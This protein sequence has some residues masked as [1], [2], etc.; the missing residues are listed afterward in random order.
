MVLEKDYQI[1]SFK[2]DTDIYIYIFFYPEAHSLQNRCVS[3]A[4]LCLS[5]TLIA[6]ASDPITFT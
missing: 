2:Q 3:L 1:R 5:N 6:N 4:A